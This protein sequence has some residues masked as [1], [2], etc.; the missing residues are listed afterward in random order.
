MKIDVCSL[1]KFGEEPHMKSFYEKGVIF[2][3]NLDVFRK[4]EDGDLREDKYET[5]YKQSEI[6]N[7]RIFLGENKV[8]VAE[9]GLFQLWYD[10]PM[11]NIFSMYA[12][13]T[14]ENLTDI[15]IDEECKKFG[16]TCVFI[17]DINE[18]ISRVKKA[19][20]SAGYELIYSPVEYFDLKQ[21]HGKWSVFNKPLRYSYQS[22]FRFF[23]KRNSSFSLRNRFNRRYSLYCRK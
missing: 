21:F 8:G 17:L 15:K 16:D 19:A 11:G 1:I 10:R 13:K 2:M 20:E 22:E 18:F 9:K 6:N 7:V 5:L 4:T 23:I 12:L 14:R 3:N